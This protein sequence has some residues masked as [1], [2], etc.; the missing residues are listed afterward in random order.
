MSCTNCRGV[1]D[2]DKGEGQ[3]KEKGRFVLDDTEEAKAVSTF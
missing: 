2:T 1:T 3:W